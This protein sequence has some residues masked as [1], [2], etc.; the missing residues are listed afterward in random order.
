MA[1]MEDQTVMEGTVASFQL[2]R[3]FPEPG[4]TELFFLRHL[5]NFPQPFSVKKSRFVATGDHPQTPVFD[6]RVVQRRPA[7]PSN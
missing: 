7:P 2:Y 5:F 4:F 1:A 6:R 3:I